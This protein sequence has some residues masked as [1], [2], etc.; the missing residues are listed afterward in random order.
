MFKDPAELQKFAFNYAER[1]LKILLNEALDIPESDIPLGF[2]KEPWYELSYIPDG[3]GNIGF[4][5]QKI[6]LGICPPEYVS[7]KLIAGTPGEQTHIIMMMLNAVGACFDA[8]KKRNPELLEGIKIKSSAKRRIAYLSKNG[9]KIS[10]QVI[11]I[12]ILSED[13]PE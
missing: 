12:T 13:P 11:G 10:H 6:Q 9:E 4:G 5:M 3:Q 7:P 8:L 1:P 2:L